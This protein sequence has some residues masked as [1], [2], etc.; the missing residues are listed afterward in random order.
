MLR[1]GDKYLPGRQCAGCGMKRP[2]NEL[3][4]VAADGDGM[5][6]F[7]E[8]GRMPGRGAYIC[9]NAACLE[10]ALLKKSFTRILRRNIIITDEAVQELKK[11]ITETS[12]NE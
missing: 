4:R 9:R 10:R 5:L 2:R 7:D 3:L 8:A 11:R 1:S 12:D 6:R